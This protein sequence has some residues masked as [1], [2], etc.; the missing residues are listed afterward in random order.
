MLFLSKNKFIFALV[1]NIVYAGQLFMTK[2]ILYLEDG[3][4]PTSFGTGGR[5][6]STNSRAGLQ[7]RGHLSRPHGFTMTWTTR[8]STLAAGSRVRAGLQHG[9][10]F[11]R[12]RRFTTPGRLICLA[13]AA[14]SPA[15]NF[16]FTR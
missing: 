16:S 2:M 7:R 4:T 13:P 5:R 9:G 12:P 6:Y 11:A 3:G 15:G 10:Q 1:C 14:D 8:P